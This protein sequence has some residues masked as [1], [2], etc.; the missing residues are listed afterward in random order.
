MKTRLETSVGM[1]MKYINVG[2]RSENSFVNTANI[3]ELLKNM[4]VH[5]TSQEGKECI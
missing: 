1:F 3:S 4:V 5:T 2:T